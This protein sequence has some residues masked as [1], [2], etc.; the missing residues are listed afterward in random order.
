MAKGKGWVAGETDKDN[1]ASASGHGKHGT[2]SDA[3]WAQKK[4]DTKNS[5][6]QKWWW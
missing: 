6:D 2:M 5:W 4:D 3:G 1:G